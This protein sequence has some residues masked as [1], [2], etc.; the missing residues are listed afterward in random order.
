MC[1]D[2]KS[3]EKEKTSSTPLVTV[4]DLQR[5]KQF[6][7]IAIR[8][9]MMPFKTQFTPDFQLQ[10]NGLWGKN[11]PD[12]EY[13]LRE[14]REVQLFDI[15]EFVKAKK[16]EKMEEM[17]A[18]SDVGPMGGGLPGMSGGNPFGRSNPFA[19]TSPFGP[20]GLDSLLGSSP[21]ESSSGGGTFNVDDL[22]KKID[23]KI[24]ELE[25]EERLEKEKEETSRKKDKIVDAEI[26][27]EEIKDSSMYEDG[28]NSDAFFDDFFSD[29]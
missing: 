2:V 5:L 10:K 23:A 15:R 8:L 21:K 29:D 14:K 6:E 26:R 7:I 17:M 25:E 24:A 13:T 4:S 16:K 19:G 22:V 20:S 18:N 28:T 3:K 12:A 11:Y 9:R 1:G 27:E